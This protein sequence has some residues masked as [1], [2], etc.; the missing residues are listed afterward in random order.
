MMPSSGSFWRSADAESG[1]N[2]GSQRLESVESHRAR[3]TAHA[4]RRSRPNNSKTQPGLY[5]VHCSRSVCHSLG[6]PLFHRKKE[7]RLSIFVTSVSRR[8]VPRF[9]EN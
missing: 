5:P 9:S 1:D 2:V 4:H 3:R 7:S 6:N 8:L